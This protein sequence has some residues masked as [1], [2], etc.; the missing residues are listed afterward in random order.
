[1]ADYFLNNLPD[2]LIPTWD[3]D[4][5]AESVTRDASAAAIAASGMF[6][7]SELDG[8]EVGSSELFGISK[9]DY[10]LAA[11]KLSFYREQ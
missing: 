5:K 11:E 10:P 9:K 4:L 2:D 6:L 7:L 8:S 3:L 1:M